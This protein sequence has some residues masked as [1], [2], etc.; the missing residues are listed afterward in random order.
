M[1]SDLR[2]FGCL[3]YLN[4]SATATHKLS[5][6]SVPCVFLGYPSSHKGY[7]CLNLVTQKLII[8]RHIIFDETVFPFVSGTPTATARP[9][10]SYCPRHPPTCWR[11]V[12][13]WVT[14]HRPPAA[15]LPSPKMMPSHCLPQCAGPGHRLRLTLV[16]RAH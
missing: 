2:V 10:T 9:W 6:R 1:Y 8:S 4:T 16:A 11:M 14:C 13:V 7:R 3:C 12:L 15:L 5:P